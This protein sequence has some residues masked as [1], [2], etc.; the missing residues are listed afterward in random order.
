MSLINVFSVLTYYRCI[1]NLL[2]ILILIYNQ[3]ALTIDDPV[4]EVIANKKETPTLAEAALKL[5][6]LQQTQKT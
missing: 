3:K 1:S 2:I 6:K 5:D 4:V